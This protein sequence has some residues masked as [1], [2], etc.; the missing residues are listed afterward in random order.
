MSLVE[1]P[2]RVTWSKKMIALI[3]E[4]DGV[5]ACAHCGTTEDLTVDHILTSSRGGTDDLANLQIL[6]RRCNS[7]KHNNPN[8]PRK[9]INMEPPPTV[10]IVYQKE[11]D[12][13]S[14]VSPRRQSLQRSS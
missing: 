13:S 7:H 10:Y 12:E 1:K 4:R 9:A 14:L 8:V 11:Y 6:C 3:A 5:R 2:K